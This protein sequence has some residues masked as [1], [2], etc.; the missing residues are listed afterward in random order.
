MGN[1]LVG[2]LRDHVPDFYEDCLED[3]KN[4]EPSPQAHISSSKVF[5]GTYV[6]RITQLPP[7]EPGDQ[8]KWRGT[9]FIMLNHFHRNQQKKL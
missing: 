5:R 6:P 4:S 7:G 2:F 1:S 3:L 9:G 8:G